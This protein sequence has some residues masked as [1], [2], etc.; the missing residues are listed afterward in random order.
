MAEEIKSNVNVHFK[1]DFAAHFEE[2]S[3]H[4]PPNVAVHNGPG[5]NKK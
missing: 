2:R 3:A 5:I 4:A 1:I